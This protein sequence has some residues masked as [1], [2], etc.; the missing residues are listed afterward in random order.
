MKELL[1]VN[2]LTDV[3]DD[4]SHLRFAELGPIRAVEFL[5]HEES[6][7][8]IGFLRGAL[9]LRAV[10]V[11]G[12]GEAPAPDIYWCSVAAT[13]AFSLLFAAARPAGPP[14]A[15]SRTFFSARFLDVR[16]C[17]LTL[18]ICSPFSDPKLAPSR[19]ESK[20][21]KPVKLRAYPVF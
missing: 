14:F 10:F 2:L 8:E 4:I 21:T 7:G 17:H 16:R 20:R 3:G 15:E 9:A 12:A 1:A 6:L 13:R 19:Y 11:G 18:I 5:R